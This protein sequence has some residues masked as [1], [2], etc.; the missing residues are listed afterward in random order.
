MGSESIPTEQWAQVVEKSGGPVVYKKIPVPKPGPDEVLIN[1][2]YSGVCHTD[3]HAMMGDWPLPTKLPLVGG[4]EG[5]GVVVARGELVK[6]IEIGDYAGIK[7][8][9]GSC[10]D[11]YYCRQADEPL[12]PEPS[13]SGYTVDG[14]FQQYA[15]GKANH[16]ARIPKECDLEAISPILCAG[17]TVYKAIKESGVR[18]GQYL[19]IV[20]AGGGLGSMALQYAKAMGIHTIAIDGGEEK[21]KMCKEI[22]ASEYVDFTKS[23]NVVQDV[24]NATADQLG[25]H[26]VIV[27]AVSEGPFQQAS[28]YVR[29]RGTIVCVGLPANA[30]LKAPVFDTVTRMINIKGSY[31][32]NRQDSAEA[33]EFF[34]RGL[35]KAPYKT[36]GLSQ[37]QDV[38]HL[39]EKGQ[40]A[41]RYV[42]DTSK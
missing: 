14:S 10:M 25:P 39:M 34:R 21:G 19:T 38:Y 1:I 7:W 17:I 29:S 9:N 27:L 33:I 23:K 24:K 31:V 42:V 15:I 11:C 41:G 37:L 22:G 18:P 28:E 8:L 5:A 12:C 3:L 13:L 32:G 20:G 35:I 40:I 30:Y 6:D 2:K 16:V 4:H 36:V 26:A